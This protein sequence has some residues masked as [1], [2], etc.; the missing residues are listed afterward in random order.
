MST[1]P[2]VLTPETQ[3]AL[4]RAGQKATSATQERD[5]LIREA[6][7]AGGSLREIGDAVG[8]SHQAV[9]LIGQRSQPT[10]DAE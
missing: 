7:A 5:R 10:M 6:L 3:K 2:A 8:L 1:V 4:R 9:K